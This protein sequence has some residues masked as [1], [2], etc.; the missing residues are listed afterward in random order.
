MSVVS[1]SVASCGHVPRSTAFE[2]PASRTGLPASRGANQA[3]V[4]GVGP[5]CAAARAPGA[6]G[7]A[8]GYYATV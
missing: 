4:C 6:P 2:H 7:G 5:A 8:R 1:A 3:R